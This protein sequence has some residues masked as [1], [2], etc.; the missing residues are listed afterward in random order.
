MNKSYKEGAKLASQINQ[1]SFQITSAQVDFKIQVQ[2][3]KNILLRGRNI[4]DREKYLSS[5]QNQEK[6]FNFSS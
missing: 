6:N 4:S 5:F 3:W 2:E 1:T